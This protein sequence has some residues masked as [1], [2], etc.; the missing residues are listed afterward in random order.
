VIDKIIGAKIEGLKY[1][2]K[3]HLK[4]VINKMGKEFNK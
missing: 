4:A 1:G 2:L 3:W